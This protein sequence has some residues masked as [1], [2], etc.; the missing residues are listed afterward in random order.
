[1]LRKSKKPIKI[2]IQCECGDN[3]FIGLWKD[4]GL[5]PNSWLVS[6]AKHWLPFKIRL[7]EALILV[8]CPYKLEDWEEFVISDKRMKQV[9]TKIFRYY[10]KNKTRTKKN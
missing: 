5:A 10:E 7:K 2:P 3:R 4:E 6:I 9:A 8:F 1:M